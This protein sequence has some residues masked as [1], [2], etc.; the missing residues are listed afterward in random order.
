MNCLKYLA[1]L[2]LGKGKFN[3]QRFE[4]E[5]ILNLDFYVR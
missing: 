2:I 3:A 1:K 4:V 5:T